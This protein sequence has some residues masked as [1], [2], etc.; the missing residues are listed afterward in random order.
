MM[1]HRKY[2]TLNAYKAIARMHFAIYKV[3]CVVCK[4]NIVPVHTRVASVEETNLR[5]V[6]IW[7]GDNW[8]SRFR[9]NL[10]RVRAVDA[11]PWSSNVA[12]SHRPVLWSGYG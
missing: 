12:A 2:H 4:N 9:A 7:C 6:V 5:L 11:I 10:T 1:K 8:F 3:V